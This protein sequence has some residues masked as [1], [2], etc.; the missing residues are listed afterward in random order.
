MTKASSASSKSR[1][2]AVTYGVARHRGGPGLVPGLPRL[3]LAMALHRLTLLLTVLFAGCRAPTPVPQNPPG[4]ER[5]LFA[6]IRASDDLTVFAEALGA[7]GLAETLSGP[8][9]YTVFAPTNAALAALSED[10][11][12][13][14]SQ[15]ASPQRVNLLAYHLVPARLATKD[16][17]GEVRSVHGAPLFLTLDDSAASVNRVRLVRRDLAARNG[18]LHVVDAVLRPPGA[19]E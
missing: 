12:A 3:L 8:G 6:N 17:D 10:L 13:E 18:V 1:T 15:R 4:P 2:G 14:L 9:P 16:F 7:A 11:R 19:Q 5:T